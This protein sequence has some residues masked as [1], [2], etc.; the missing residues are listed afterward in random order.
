VTQTGY[1]IMI[2]IHYFSCLKKSRR[3][4]APTDTTFTAY[5]AERLVQFYS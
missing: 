4:T 5:Q 2:D 1:G 3:I